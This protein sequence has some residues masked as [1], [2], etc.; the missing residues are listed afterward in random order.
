MRDVDWTL[1]VVITE[2]VRE[3]IILRIDGAT[4]ARWGEDFDRGAASEIRAGIA[5]GRYTR[6]PPDWATTN[7]KASWE[8]YVRNATDDRA[9]VVLVQAPGTIVVKTV[10]SRAERHS[11]EHRVRPGFTHV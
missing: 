8:L 11:G 6:H 10:L 5:V 1:P 3:R 2:H 4:K 7:A 9:W